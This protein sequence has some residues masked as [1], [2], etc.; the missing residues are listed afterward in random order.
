MRD[1][2]S[3]DPLEVESVIDDAYA[4]AEQIEVFQDEIEDA[5]EMVETLPYA[6]NRSGEYTEEQLKT[7]L[8]GI[9]KL[10]NIEAAIQSA[11]EFSNSREWKYIDTVRQIEEDLDQLAY[12]PAFEHG[13]LIIDSEI[14]Q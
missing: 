2:V 3:Y 7:S 4:Q 13:E 8:K 11:P 1:K 6:V 10:E 5:I 14:S 12:Q 9:Y